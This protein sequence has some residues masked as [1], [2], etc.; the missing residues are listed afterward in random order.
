MESFGEILRKTREEKNLDIVKISR[1]ISIEKRYLTGLEEEDSSAFPGEAYMIG[2]LRNYA[3]YLELDA[4]FILKL[5]NNKKI[6]ESPVPEGLIVQHKK[7]WILPVVL[8]SV[9]A[10]LIATGIILF[11]VFHKNKK[12][13]EGIVGDA[14]NLVKKQYELSN[15]KFLQ[16][17]YKGEQLL[18]PT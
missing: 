8:S 14:N 10:V 7:N 9:V 5:Y 11:F 3:N 15:T 13:D 1:E 18:I 4:E 12:V 2:F 6:Q 16:R 17:V